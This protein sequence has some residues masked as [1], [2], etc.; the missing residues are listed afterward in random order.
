MLYR[1]QIGDSL[2]KIARD[3]LGNMS[4]WPEIARLN[5]LQPPYIIHP[6][7]LLLLPALPEPASQPRTIT[8]EKE[9]QPPQQKKGGAGWWL[10]A[11][12]CSPRMWG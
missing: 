11:A 2:S 10:V 5:S 7:E 4:R 1:V 9:I 6:N 3:Q 8:I 12:G